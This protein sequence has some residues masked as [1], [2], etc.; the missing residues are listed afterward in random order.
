MPNII[1]IYI[2]KILPNPQEVPHYNPI[3]V[4]TVEY[5]YIGIHS[6]SKLLFFFLSISGK[7]I[8]VFSCLLGRICAQEMVRERT[9]VSKQ[10]SLLWDY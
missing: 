6:C 5:Y 2:Q 3:Q 8:Q 1:P 4:K 7:E 10:I 9:A